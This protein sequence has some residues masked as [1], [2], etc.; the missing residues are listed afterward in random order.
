MSV[1]YFGDI[2]LGQTIELPFNAFTSDNPSISA[3]ITNLTAGDIHIHRGSNL[4]QRNNAA[5]ITVS[6]D[7]DSI[8][9]NHLVE[10]DTSD[11]TVA[12]F[13][14]PGRNY[15]VRMEGTTIDGGTVNA[16]IGTFS[17]ENRTLGPI[18]GA[19]TYT[20]TFAWELTGMY[21]GSRGLPCVEIDPQSVDG[22]THLWELDE[23]TTA[24][25]GSPSTDTT[26]IG[27]NLTSISNDIAAADNLE[28]AGE[29]YSAT[30]G[31]SGTA[32]PDAVAD[33]AGGLPISDA[34]GL[35]LDTQIGTDIDAI[36]ADTNELQTDWANGGRLDLILDA[37]LAMLDDARSEP[38]DTAPPVNPDMA[39]KV[40]YLYKFMRNKIETTATRIHVYDDAGTNKDHT[41]VI[42]D[43]GTTF[44]RGEFAAGDA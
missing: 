34:G 10:I 39:T 20:Y 18:S 22:V 8:T 32:L 14:Q 19:P 44:T 9:G 27:V 16:F 25:D 26:R 17:I 15:H 42:S 31:F 36:L 41:S 4:T 1:P 37:I 40:D 5:G 7:L 29:N 6:I 30:R 3:T 28:T 11:N 35:D 23:L 21:L 38:G 12:D 2:L 33:D 24:T 43:D 13:W